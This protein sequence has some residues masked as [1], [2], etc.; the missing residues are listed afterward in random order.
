MLRYAI[1]CDVPKTWR[2]TW[3]NVSLYRDAFFI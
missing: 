3:Y 1:Q 2:E